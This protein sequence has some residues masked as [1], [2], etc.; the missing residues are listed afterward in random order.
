MGVLQTG[1]DED[2][3]ILPLGEGEE[4]RVGLIVD[5]L[6]HVLRTCGCSSIASIGDDNAGVFFSKV[7]VA[8]PFLATTDSLQCHA[9]CC[10]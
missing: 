7:D 10:C 4:V 5:W 2:V 9:A 6:R 1:N 3:G 8:C